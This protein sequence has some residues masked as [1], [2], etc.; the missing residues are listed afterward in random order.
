MCKVFVTFLLQKSYQLHL[1]VSFVTL[2]HIRTLLNTRVQREPIKGKDTPP[3]KH[4]VG[5]V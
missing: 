3:L 2:C 4:F 1:T 5:F